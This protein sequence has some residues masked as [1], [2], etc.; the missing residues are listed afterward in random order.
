[1]GSGTFDPARFKKEER[2]RWEEGAAGWRQMWPLLERAAQ[3][4]SDRLIALAQLKDGDRVLD[5]ATGGGEPALSAARVVGARGKVIGIDHSSAM[6]EFAR[7]R[8]ADKGVAN[9]EFR[10]ADA[11]SAEFARGE[12]DAVLSRWG[13]MFLPDVA[14]TLARLHAVLKP[15]GRVAISVWAALEKVPALSVAGVAIR[16][17]VPL[18]P[19]D[20]RVPGPF[21]LADTDSLQKMLAA[22]GFRDI[23]I[24][25]LFV[26]FEYPSVEEYARIT[27]VLGFRQLLDAQP[28][29]K[30]AAISAA[31]A[32]AARPFVTAQGVVKFNNQAIVVGARA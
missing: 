31:L 3:P 14:G 6:L 13:L 25:P 23:R 1:M 8:A 7:E 21:S 32:E 17:V 27:G 30:R 20:P 29:D 18:P 10:Q 22:G 11:E 5:V 2:Q 26:T 19:P 15:D 9:V 16:K 12:F 24:E 4:V 28:P